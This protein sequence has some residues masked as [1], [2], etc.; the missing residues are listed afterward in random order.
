VSGEVLYLSDFYLTLK[1]DSGTR[2]TF[3]R[4]GDVPKVQI[5]DP[6]H[7]HVALLRTISDESMHDLTA[8]LATLK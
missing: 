3:R 2:H 6:L 7:A 4:Q 8:F 5:V 1:D